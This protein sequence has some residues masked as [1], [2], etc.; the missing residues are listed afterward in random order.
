MEINYTHLSNHSAGIGCVCGQ[1]HGRALLSQLAERLDIVLR[2]IKRYR[3]RPAPLLHRLRYLHKTAA[4][5]VIS[6][7]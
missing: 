4:S 1:K 3:I 2:N 7:S 5:D 6:F